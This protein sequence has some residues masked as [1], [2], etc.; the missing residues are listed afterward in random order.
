MVR[1]ALPAAGC[2]TLPLVAARDVT[3]H[4]GR[5]V[6]LAGMLAAS[7]TAP[8]RHGEILQFATLDDPTG[9]AECLLLPPVYRRLGAIVARGGAVWVEGRAE[10]QHGASTLRVERLGTLPGETLALD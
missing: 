10:V 2:A 1:G 6:R 5:R 8:T 3:R 4:A 7:R 9:L